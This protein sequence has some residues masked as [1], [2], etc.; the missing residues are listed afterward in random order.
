IT[1]QRYHS[2]GSRWGANYRIVAHEPNQE[3][4]DPVVVANGSVIIFSWMDNRRSAAWDIY[5]K[6]VTWDWE[7]A[8]GAIFNKELSVNSYQLMQNYPNPFNPETNINF[9]LP[10]DGHITLSVYDITG[11]LVKTLMNEYKTAGYYTIK[12]TC[13]NEQ[14]KMVPSGLYLYQIMSGKYHSVKK[15]IMVK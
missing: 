15:M 1:G 9:A 7:G 12:W 11:R 13:K 6:I 2:D 10:K 14:D 4:E 3:K 8:T 5:S